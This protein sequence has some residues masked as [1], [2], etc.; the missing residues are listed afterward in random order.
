M[1]KLRDLE[2]VERPGF[3][4]WNDAA[5]K[6]LKRKHPPR[7]EPRAIHIPLTFLEALFGP[8]QTKPE[9]ENPAKNKLAK[10]E[11]FEVAPD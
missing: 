11:I 1:P 6:A 9:H 5:P 4:S 8:L 10:K 3:V 7:K 2:L